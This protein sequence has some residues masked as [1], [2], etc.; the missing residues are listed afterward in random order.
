MP[1][2]VAEIVAGELLARASRVAGEATRLFH[3]RGGTFPGAEG[4]CA[5]WFEPLLFITLYGEEAEA[6]TA[7]LINAAKEALGE[8]V[9]SIM[10]QRRYLG[11]S[12]A[13]L[14]EGSL[15]DKPLAVEGGLSYLIRPGEAQ[16]IGFFG[17]MSKGRALVRNRANKKR[18]L[19]L[20]SY[21]CSFSVAALA[22]GAESVVNLDM[23]RGALSLGRENHMVNGFD[24]RR[25]AF[26]CHDL[27][28]SFS[29]L[30][31]LAPFDMV[32]VDPPTSQGRSF[33]AERDWPRLLS[34]LPQLIEGGAEVIAALN[35]PHLPSTFLE[36]QFTAQLPEA[37]LAG[38]YSSG[39]D[40]PEADPE[41]GLK[42]LHYKT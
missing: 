2:E 11:G 13:E 37:L 25:A 31:K 12:P 7:P 32:I 1:N 16:N 29:K 4:L 28:K 15:P 38:R 5:D 34:R 33:T 26:L 6:L 17:D 14:I 19:N 42:I 27:F 40:Y 8:R 20:F 24:L 23:S 21:T 3:G 9:G 36:E 22:G 39:E 30:R 18:V 41:R 35:A 10:I